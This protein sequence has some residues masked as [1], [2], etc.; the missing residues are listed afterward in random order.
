MLIRAHC[1]ALKAL[2][3][4]VAQDF[5]RLTIWRAH[6][7]GR[8]VVVYSASTGSDTPAFYS[9]SESEEA[10]LQ[11]EVFSWSAKEDIWDGI[12]DDSL[13]VQLRDD[14]MN[15]FS[16]HLPPQQRRMNVLGEYVEE[17]QRLVSDEGA[18]WKISN[19]SGEEDH[20]L[21]INPLLAFCNQLA[22]VH[23]IFKNA[24]DASVT[25]R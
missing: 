4:A 25:V 3:G 12:I 20:V 21:P 24:P 13:R 22:W 14:F 19:Q 7:P 5:L 18:E 10:R 11:S 1:F 15:K 9:L 8:P 17:L 16:P 23:S 2:G 6:R